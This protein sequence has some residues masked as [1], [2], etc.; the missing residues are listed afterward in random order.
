MPVEVPTFDTHQQALDY[1]IMLQHAGKLPPID[2][3]RLHQG[4]VE[5]VTWS[6]D[7]GLVPP[8]TPGALQ[9]MITS[10]LG[11]RGKLPD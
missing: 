4:V 7:L 8:V 5:T 10:Q 2:W 3:S 9:A 1:F 11:A 6:G